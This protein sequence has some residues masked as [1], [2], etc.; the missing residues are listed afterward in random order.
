MFLIGW[1]AVQ[2]NVKIIVEGTTL[3]DVLEALDRK[4]PGFK[5]DI[6]SPSK[7]DFCAYITVGINGLARRH[8]SLDVPLADGDQISFVAALKGG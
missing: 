3:R 4:H 2:K 1:H 7:E 6:Y 8:L 5:N